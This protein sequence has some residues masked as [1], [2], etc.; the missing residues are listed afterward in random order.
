MKLSLNLTSGIRLK[1]WG[2]KAQANGPASLVVT[3]IHPNSNPAELTTLSSSANQSQ[4]RNNPV[5]ALRPG[6]NDRSRC[7]PQGV[8]GGIESEAN[9]SL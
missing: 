1:R 8:R 4:E 6:S 5:R 2:Q 7:Q 3:G 9:A